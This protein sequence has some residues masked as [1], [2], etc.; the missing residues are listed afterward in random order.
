MLRLVD[1]GRITISEFN[2]EDTKAPNVDLRVVTA[3]ALDELRSHPAD[4]ADAA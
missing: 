4:S 3:L 2:R 1:I